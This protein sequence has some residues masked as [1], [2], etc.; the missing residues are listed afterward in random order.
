M[1]AAAATEAVSLHQSVQTVTIAQQRHEKS[2][3]LWKTQRD[4][5]SRLSS[6]IAGLQQ[7]V[8]LV[9]DQLVSLQTQKSLKC[10]WD[11]TS[12]CV[13]PLPFNNAKF[14]WN[15]VTRHLLGQSNVSRDTQHLQAEIYET[16]KTNLDMLSSS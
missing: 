2:R 16:F 10:D 11:T 8:I 13:T 14:P 9:G 15:D 1:T 12:I 6:E 3:R 5:D 4:I 7:A